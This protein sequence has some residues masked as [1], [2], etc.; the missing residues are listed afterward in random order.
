MSISS[1]RVLHGLVALVVASG[2]GAY[3][4]AVLAQNVLMDDIVVTAQRREQQAQE[5]PVA[6]TALNADQL[7]RLQVVETLDIGRLVPNMVA[8]NN[9]GP[10][11]SN[12]YALRGL[13]NTESIA[14]FDPPVGAYVDDIYIT[15][16]NQNNLALFDVDRI[17]VLRGPQGTLFGRNTTGG[18]VRLI[19]KKPADEFGGYVEAGAGEFSRYQGR[20]SV[21]IPISDRI[22]TKFSAYYIQ[23]DGYVK[24]RNIGT[25][26]CVGGVCT[27][28][29][30]VKDNK[31][32][33]QQKSFGL[34]AAALVDIFDSLQW[35][36]AVDYIDDDRA[37]LLN[38]KQDGNRYSSTGLSPTA[39]NLAGIVTGKKSGTKLG[40]FTESINVTSVFD[41]EIGDAGTLS[42]ITGWRDLDQNFNLD[43]CDNS[44]F[45][46]GGV[47]GGA[48][49][50]D[51]PP[52]TP[53]NVAP[54]GSFTIANDGKH[55]QLSQEIKWVSSLGDSIDYVAGFFYLDEDNNTDFGDIFDVG[56][57]LVLADRVLKNTT[58]TTAA[59]LQA[60]YAVTDQ[61]TITAGV[62]YTDEEKQIQYRDFT[63]CLPTTI[64][65]CGFTDVDGNG[66][67]DL[68]LWTFNF[69]LN[70]IPTSQDEDVWTPR[71]A[72]EY[73][74][75]DGL[76]FY[77]S[78]TRGFKSG[79]WNARGTA[80][81]AL[82]D[83]D[84]ETVWSYEVGMKSD[85]LDNRLR[86]NLTLFYADI[87][88]FQLPAAVSIGG[89]PTFIT[90]NFAD[91]E[92]KGLEAE[93]ILV[94]VD[95]LTLFMNV[96]IQD[97]EY[98]SVDPSIKQQQADC[99]A[100]LGGGGAGIVDPSCNIADPVRS[101]DWTL[102]VGFNYLWDLGGGYELIPSAYTYT[103][104][105]HSVGTSGTDPARVSGYTNIN[106]SVALNNTESDW[107]LTAEC[108]N[109]TDRKM[110]VSTLVDFQYL[111][112]PRTWLVR[113]KKGF[114]GN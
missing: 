58:E 48:P 50:K 79:G 96:G 7:E 40:N 49:T 51:D 19:L 5:V 3:S 59:Y 22:K 102:N 62:R 112:A 72:A 89:V 10:G 13:N 46:S 31:D 91:L 78:A 84:K 45:C 74:P 9:T 105:E 90:Q 27:T 39:S 24:N 54:W 99:R 33:N 11:T 20:G 53:G 95:A 108:R 85:W 88:D 52:R 38:W 67:H 1:Q 93:F 47:A 41:W 8:H 104:D 83:F 82:L 32:I 107:Q 68:D 97:N 111:Q 44:P 87:E 92:N 4:T 43:F 26:N 36:I 29:P 70:G 113:F 101:P 69:P 75:R 63:A 56:I 65:D 114:G 80:A 98:K 103:V 28:D 73:Q 12:N 61:W 64:P 57:P 15:R 14:T 35:H 17:E 23:D 25:R 42:F 81:N 37:N 34:R 100:G 71:F 109:C 6:I 18:A 86:A 55:K 77:A 94:P 106:A 66:V 16:Q 2:S 21:D 110:V 30:N 60:D 76:A